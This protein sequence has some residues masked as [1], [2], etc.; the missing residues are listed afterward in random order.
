[1]SSAAQRVD[2]GELIDQGTLTTP[3]FLVV[4]LC[5][6]VVLMDG[7]DIQTMALAVPSLA[8]EWGIAPASFSLA[9]SASV[10]G[11]LIGTALVAPVGDRFGRRPMLI[12][13]MAVVGVASIATAFSSTPVHLIVWRLLTGIGL[14]MSL[15]NA[16][17]LTSEYVP[18]R[19]RAFLISAMYIS[20]ALGALIAGFLAPVLID[21]FGWRSIFLV[22]GVGPLCV[23]VLLVI[24]IPES[25]RLLL[26]A[27]PDDARIPQIVRRFLPGVDPATVVAGAE[28]RTEKRNVLALF[29]PEFRARTTLLWG[30]FALNLFV[31]FVL[32]SWLPT[33]L[34]DAGWTRAQALRGAVVI[35]AGGILGGL[36]ISRLVDRGKTIAAMTG[37]YVIVAVAFGLFL[38]FPPTLTNWTILLL[39]V[40]AGVSGS[41]AALTALS[42]IFY[43]PGIRATGAGW[44]SASGRAGAVVAP[45]AGGVVLGQLNL[46]PEEHLAL[47]IPPVLLCGLCMMLLRFAWLERS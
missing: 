21:A 18:R 20:I 3:R 42:A 22:G 5:A 13:G 4:A 45:L 14:G 17:A 9:L 38:V 36:L 32:I 15:P 25:L 35:Q 41:Q 19:T 44:A 2:V 26:S 39:I 27:S 24:Y 12:V 30:V 10:F 6:L 1:M 37:T 31:L 23:A 7:Y 46:A 33:I 43:P 16:T 34:T 11:M 28:G 40:G 29:A 8:D 47:L